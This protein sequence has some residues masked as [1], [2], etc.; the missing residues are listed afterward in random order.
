MKQNTKWFTGAL[1]IVTAAGLIVWA[2]KNR[3]RISETLKSFIQEA[4]DWS[5]NEEVA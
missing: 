5:K 3:D 4:K 1:T 2:W